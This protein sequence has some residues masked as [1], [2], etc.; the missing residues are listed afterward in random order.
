MGTSVQPGKE[1]G[2]AEVFAEL[3]EQYLP[4]VFRYI[5][6]RVSNNALAEDLTSSVFEKALSKMSSYRRDE[7]SF[8]TWLLAIARHQVIDHYRTS[9]KRQAVPLEEAADVPS[10]KASPEEE[11]IRKEELERLHVYLAELP[12]REQEVISLKF[13]AEMTNRQISGVLG[14]SESNVGTILYR[15]VGKL[16]YRFKE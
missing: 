8:A 12:E 16:R 13:G 3:Y 11:L 9:S 1:S 7:A 5:R 2:A 6:Y 15:A 4:R 14:L 10:K